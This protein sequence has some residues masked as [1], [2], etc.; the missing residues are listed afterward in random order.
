MIFYLSYM[1]TACFGDFTGTIPGTG[2][3]EMLG[4]IDPLPESALH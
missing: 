4:K 2:Q 1:G 3:V